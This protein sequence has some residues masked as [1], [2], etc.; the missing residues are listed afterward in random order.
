MGTASERMANLHALTADEVEL[1][2]AER[3]LKVEQACVL[4]NCSPRTLRRWRANEI[5][6]AH[7]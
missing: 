3:L 2:R 4:L 7:V 1:E 6:R 5:G